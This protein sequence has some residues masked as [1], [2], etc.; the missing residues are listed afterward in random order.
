[1]MKVVCKFDLWCNSKRVFSFLMPE[2]KLYIFYTFLLRISL[3]YVSINYAI[4]ITT[5]RQC[6]KLKQPLQ[7]KLDL[8]VDIWYT[9]TKEE[10]LEF[11]LNE[12]KQKWLNELMC[13]YPW[14]WNSFITSWFLFMAGWLHLNSNTQ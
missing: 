3:L 5:I 1:M 7:S 11:L 8:F 2:C 12:L 14:E 6:I 10:S 4:L 13:Q 9:C